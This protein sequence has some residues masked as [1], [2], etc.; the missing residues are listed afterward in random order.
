MP[1]TDEPEESDELTGEYRPSPL[2]LWMFLAFSILLTA[3]AFPY[4]DDSPKAVLAVTGPL[5]ILLIAGALIRH[6]RA[7][8]KGKPD[9]GNAGN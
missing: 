9:Q 2:F 7:Q 3:Q 6:Y 8:R 1:E 4:D 5:T